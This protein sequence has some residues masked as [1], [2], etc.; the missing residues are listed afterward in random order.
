VV[1]RRD[2]TQETIRSKIVTRLMRGDRVVVQT[3]GGAGHGPLSERD[4][5]LAAADVAD[6]K[7]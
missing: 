7:V 4:P 3:A 1:L 6:G 5:A 2:G